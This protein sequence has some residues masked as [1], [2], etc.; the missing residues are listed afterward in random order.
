MPGRRAAVRGEE[1][2]GPGGGAGGGRDGVP[3]KRE[4]S[5]GVARQYT[6]TTRR[7]ERRRRASCPWPMPGRT[8]AGR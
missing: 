7:V 4:V 2:R 6:G 8:A 1:S 3:E 5:A